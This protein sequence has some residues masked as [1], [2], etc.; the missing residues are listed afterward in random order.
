MV[1][2]HVLGQGGII[3]NAA[4]NEVVYW[5]AWFFEICAFC[6][7]NCFALISGY[8]MVGKNIKP[9]N[10]INMWFQV[11]FYSMLFTALFFIFMP[12]SRGVKNLVVSV[13][14]IIGKQWWYISSYFA[15]FF[16][17]P[18]LNTA[19]EH[20]SEQT[21]K[22]FLIIVLIAVCC[23]DGI[24]PTDAFQLNGG[25]SVIWL[26]IV[27]LFGA[28]IKKYNLAQKITALK[29]IL[30]F[31]T[32]IIITFISKLGIHFL[33]KLILGQVKYDGILI[34]YTSITILLSAVF[35]FLFFLNIKVN[36]K[37]SK[38][39]IFFSP[40][41]LGVYLIHVHPLVFKYII[42]DMFVPLVNKPVIIMIA[43]VL[44]GTFGIFIICS[45]I[46][47]LRIQFFKLIK[48]NKLSE[49]IE[50]KTNRIYIKIFNK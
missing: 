45:I 41:T 4:P 38:F 12:E 6:A 24:I 19:I 2:L 23:L 27:Y 14:P 30:G 3:N 15:L 34:S 46:E 25:Y 1:L 33:T 10:L 49:I 31:F 16:F 21:Y 22:K 37:I 7:V 42:K 26:I 47:L 20:I 29:S 13:L 9:K 50:N 17:I 28:Y 18:F 5:V 32:M 36:N 11:L 8:V 48:I 39:V 35:L 40:A 43:C 44:V